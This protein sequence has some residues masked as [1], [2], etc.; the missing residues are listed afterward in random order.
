MARVTI[1][2]PN[3]LT[4][5]S[6]DPDEIGSR[7]RAY[8][9]LEAAVQ[10]KT[11]SEL[12]YGETFT[13][14]NGEEAEAD[15]LSSYL[16][17]RSLAGEVIGVFE[18]YTDVTD[19][20]EQIV[21]TEA[22]KLAILV[23]SFGAVYGL[24]L[25]TVS[26]GSRAV[27]KKHEENLQ[28][29][30]AAARAETANQAKS[31][32]LANMSHEL[33]T[34]LNA[35][36]GFSEL[37]KGETFGPVE[38]PR[39]RD[40]AEDIHASGTHLL[41]II[42]DVL[43]LVKVESGRSEMS[44]VQTDP[45]PI[46]E[47][48]VH[49]IRSQADAAQVELSLRLGHDL[50]SLATD[51]RRVKQILTNLLSNAVKFTSQG[52]RVSIGARWREA[53]QVLE[54]TVSDTGIGIAAEDIPTTLSPFGRIDTSTDSRYPGTGLGLPLAQR[55]AHMLGGELVL[56]SRLGQGTAVTLRLPREGR[57]EPEPRSREAA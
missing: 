16:A 6:S 31:E 56:N 40:Y 12:E 22:L 30:A 33:R 3:G 53:A 2:S 11:A 52:G 14:F 25:Y 38:P 18:M 36:I 37:I 49:M 7:K 13:D 57:T 4:V 26:L 29:T 45:C 42:D 1:Y 46:I 32:F 44:I 5:F 17:V 21:A 20:G 28:L 50:P 43:D 39:Y 15:L 48:A 54:I 24:L 27:A 41:G 9:G 8:A 55:F 51:G 35:I 34:P 10:G 19:L 47:E 23:L